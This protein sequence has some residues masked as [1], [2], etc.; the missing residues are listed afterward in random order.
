MREQTMDTRNEHITTEPQARAQSSA[1]QWQGHA[2]DHWW[3]RAA[4]PK[5][6]ELSPLQRFDLLGWDEA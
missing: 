5:L 4:S 6:G 3:L 1:P 2:D